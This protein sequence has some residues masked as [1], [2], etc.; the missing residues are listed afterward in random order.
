[1]RFRPILAL[2]PLA[3]LVGCGEKAPQSDG[4]AATGEVLEGTISDAM[5]PLDTV[6]SQPPLA[7]PERGGASGRGGGE[8]A[9]PGGEATDGAI[10]LPAEDGAEPIEVPTLEAEG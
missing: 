8:G 6:R 2:V 7:K 10:D 5:L 1:M 3:L 9:P 4:R